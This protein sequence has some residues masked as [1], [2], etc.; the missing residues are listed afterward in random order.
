[1]RRCLILRIPVWLLIFCVMTAGIGSY[2]VQA[3]SAGNT[4]VEGKVVAGTLPP[5][6]PS[7]QPD[8]Q[9]GDVVRNKPVKTGDN[10]DLML[11][12]LLAVSSGVSCIILGKNIK[13]QRKYG[14]HKK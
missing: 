9:Q 8:T 11:Y 3:Q 6:A 7:D 5:T 4:Q 1:M 2:S 13:R 12:F 10:N 14:Y